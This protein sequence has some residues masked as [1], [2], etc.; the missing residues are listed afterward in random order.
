M[1]LHAVTDNGLYDAIT[2]GFIRNNCSNQKGKG[3]ADAVIRL[4]QCF[5][6]YYAR[7]KTTSGWV[8]KC[9]IRHFFASIDHD[10][11]KAKLLAVCENHGIDPRI[12][13]LLCRYIDNSPQGLPLGY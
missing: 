8:L 12:F 4:K 3:T 13:G 9:D 2:S 7:Y 10:V 11:A 1:V 5:V 6:R